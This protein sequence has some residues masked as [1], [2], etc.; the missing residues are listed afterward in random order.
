MSQSIGSAS[1]N[2][3]SFF[4]PT[5]EGG[6]YSSYQPLA[7]TAWSK[8]G[9]DEELSFGDLLDVINPL[10]HLPIVS[11][12]Y[13]AITGDNIGLAARLAGDALY[14]GPMGL[15]TSG[16]MAALESGAGK[17]TGEMLAQVAQDI[18]GGASG[19]PPSPAAAASDMA[20]ASFAAEDVHAAELAAVTD[21]APAQLALASSP[22]PVP[23]APSAPNS[24]Q[25]DETSQRIARSVAE[26][27][28]AQAGLLLAS[29]QQPE[30]TRPGP[31]TKADKPT[32]NP[33][34][35]PPQTASANWSSELL[36][37]TIARYERAVAA[38][39]R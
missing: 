22:P 20:A 16:M 28:R 39:R 37:E 31:Q 5:V 21:S 36:A 24:R 17:T 7:K 35:S 13:R 3:G 25:G 19:A 32:A 30:P 1:M 4:A 23:F 15:L 18:F 8:N 10:Q 34:M 9:V 14:G 29:V 6:D 38:N 26:T 33:Y 27:Q 11:H 12:I 2:G